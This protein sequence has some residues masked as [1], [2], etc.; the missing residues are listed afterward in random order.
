[1]G[2]ASDAASV[3]QLAL[4]TD[5]LTVWFNVPCMVPVLHTS[6]VALIVAALVASAW[7]VI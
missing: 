5:T 4:V 1:L 6:H 2:S 7:I 3:C